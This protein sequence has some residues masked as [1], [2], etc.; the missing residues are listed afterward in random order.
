MTAIH[1]LFWIA[2]VAVIDALLSGDNAVVIAMAC[3]PLP[4]E[5]RNRAVRLGAA[6]AVIA[7]ILLTWFALSMLSFPGLRLVGGAAL[8]YIAVKLVLPEGEELSPKGGGVR[9][10]AAVRMVILADLSMSTD[11]V[12]AVAGVAQSAGAYNWLVAGIGLIASIPFCILGSQILMGWMDRFPM[13]V[14]AGGM[15]LGWVAGSMAASDPVVV[16][17]ML[18][19]LDLAAGGLLALAVFAI[20]AYASSRRVI[21]G[22]RHG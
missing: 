2:Q 8:F 13:L 11:N 7:R 5:Q 9:L 14:T 6:G 16:G 12:M 17:A 10:W 4:P 3:R 20:S 21:I 1:L 18:P 15:L 22:D 19:N